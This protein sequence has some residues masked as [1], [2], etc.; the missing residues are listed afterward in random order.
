[1]GTPW[2]PTNDQSWALL[3]ER[4]RQDAVIPYVGA[5]ISAGK[6]PAWS[7]L[8]ADLE[9]ASV[10]VTGLGDDARDLAARADLLGLE[11]GDGL[12]GRVWDVF[13]SEV[14]SFDAAGF[15]LA[16]RCSAN[17]QR[18]SAEALRLHASWAWEPPTMASR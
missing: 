13:R 3:E 14:A 2:A 5:G 18:K 15:A 1:M 6:I 16:H 9:K 10:S 8:I 11:V 4:M 7:A 17:A 12:P